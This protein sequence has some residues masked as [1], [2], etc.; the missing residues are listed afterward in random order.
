MEYFFETYE[1][2]REDFKKAAKK[3][4]VKY[5][6]VLVGKIPVKSK[7]DKNL[8]VDWFYLPAQKKH[9]KLLILT[10]GLHGIEGYT[11]SAIQL[12]F[13]DKILPHLSL[14]DL[15]I[16]FIHGANPYGFKYYRKVTENNVDL[17]RNCVINQ[18]KYNSKND[19]YV[20]IESFLNPSGPVAV[21]KLQYR[22]FHLNAIYKIIKESLPVLRQAAL[23]GQYEFEKGI[24]YGGKKHEPQ[25]EAINALLKD[26]VKNYQVILNVDIHTGY[27]ERGKMHLFLNPV[28]DSRVK[29]ALNLIFKDE[30]IDWGTNKDFYTINGEYVNLI[31]QTN[32][33]KLCIPMCFEIGTLDT[34]TTLGSIKSIQI[35]ISE[36][37]GAHYG[38]KDSNSEEKVKKDF[39]EMYY[40]GSEIWRTNVI[41]VAYEKMSKMMNQFMN[42]HIDVHTYQIDS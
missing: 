13:I 24:Y 33:K 7:I 38:Y 40:P 41:S 37:Q 19:G 10:S 25:I 11:G 6:N 20:K 4:S 30:K 26:V 39:M 14:D 23:Q 34:N 36:N 42:Y 12:M 8:T 31:N 2:C 16:L 9:K 28:E 22:F 3:L 17:N 5:N 15:G 32:D 27:G 21:D 29:H 35:M 18:D 1:E